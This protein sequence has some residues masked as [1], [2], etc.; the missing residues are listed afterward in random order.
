MINYVTPAEAVK[1]IRSG[2]FVHLSSVVTEPT[3]LVDAMVE[4]GRN[5]EFENVTIS[6]LHTEGPAQY[7]ATEFEGIFQLNSYFIGAN[8]RK[9][10]Q[11]GYADLIPLFLSDT[12]RLLR[13]GVLKCDVAM[14]S[15][16]EP[17]KHGYVS[18]GTSVDT[19]LAAMEQARV[20][21]AVVNKYMPRVFGDS[22]IHISKIDHFCRHDAPLHEAHFVDPTPEE[23]SIAKHCASVIEDG[24]CL[25]MG[26]G[27][28][29]NAVLSEL[30]NHKNLG[31][32]TE[33]FAD[34]ILPLVA[35]GVINGANKVLDKGKIVTTFMMGSQALYDFVDYN[36]GVLI[37]DVA[38]T[39]DP[40]ILCKNPQV[41]SIN[42]A[43]QVDITGQCCADSI[44]TKIF[45][46]VGGQ[47]DFVYGASRSERGVSIIAMQS[48]TNKGVSKIAPVLNLGSGVQTTRNHVQYVATEY[49]IV[50]LVGKSMQERALLL[51][52]I[53][54]PR[55][56]EELERAAFERFGP[57]YTH[58]KNITK[59]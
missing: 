21:I 18:L 43:L 55:H 1:A 7:T 16:S 33:M 22:F 46:G 5:R 42:S 36:P 58:I 23:V 59:I 41:T 57:H 15:V 56:R 28:I 32:H 25:Q 53:A 26:I 45:S 40:M 37:K 19:C 35:S 52:S 2:D 44:G 4:R 6:H 14:I 39:N 50:N 27:S 30:K 11:A 24:A 31:V 3:I 20:I 49:G 17:D 48:E 8:V 54:H 51:T 47:I 10:S 34:G 12:Q 38:Y 13:L 9:Q 29:P